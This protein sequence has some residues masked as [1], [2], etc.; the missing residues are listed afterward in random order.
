M[1]PPSSPP[2]SSTPPPQSRSARKLNLEERLRASFSIGELSNQTSPDPSTR[3]SP[4]PQ[5]QQQPERV[6]SPASTPL[7]D[8]PALSP[9]IHNPQ[10]MHLE[11]DPLHVL[12]PSPSHP[13]AEQITPPAETP[14]EHQESPQQQ[15]APPEETP[16]PPQPPSEEAPPADKEAPAEQP[17]SDLPA[18]PPSPEKSEN[19]ELEEATQ[20]SDVDALQERLKLVEQRFADVSSSFKRIQAEKVAADAILRDITPLESISDSDALRAY[21]KNLAFKAE[22][23]QDEIRRL[24]GKLQT[25]EER[26]EELRD[27]HRLESSSQSEQIDRL[28]RQVEEAEAL[29]KASQ[30]SITQGESSV[31]A[32]KAE[33]DKLKTDV[34][35]AHGLVKEEEE[36]RVKAISL[37]KSV[38]QKLVKAE[39]DREEAT[40]EV[41]VLKEKEKAEREKE[42]AERNRLQKEIESVNN[43]RE[44]AVAGL[45]AQFDKEVATLKERF[46]RDSAAMRSQYELEAINAKSAHKN[47]LAAKNQQI[48]SL[49]NSVQ[50]LSRDKNN[51]FEQAE[52]RQAEVESSQTALE[53][54]Q[55]Q[56]IELQYQLREVQ[57]RLALV[58][59]DLAEALRGAPSSVAEPTAPAPSTSAFTV[60]EAK[61]ETKIDD[62]TRAVATL[63][64]ERGESEAQWSRKLR[65]KS[66][67]VDLLRGT[68]GGTAE[69]KAR[70]EAEAA[71][72]RGVIERLQEEGR[73]LKAQIKDLQELI[74]KRD[75]LEGSSRAQE[76]EIAARISL[77]ERTVEEGKTREAQLRASN[78]TLREELRKV[79]SSAALLEKQRNPGVGYWRAENGS[80][81]SMSSDN[82]SRPSSPAPTTPK[83]DEEVNL[84]YLRN[85]ILQFLEHKEMRPNLVKVLSIILHFTPQETRR[86]VAKV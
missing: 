83:S 9:T 49:E 8:S 18:E 64:R 37:L 72:L 21:I 36:K 65:E 59:E 7:P 68:L 32:Y 22:V 71:E 14:Q 4:A 25:Q 60:L 84:E 81:T 15:Q 17:A 30:S 1:P 24:T 54:V 52:L 19:E 74:A 55:S 62:L 38:R 63:E 67:E 77:L 73:A 5:Q 29:V 56:N 57:D 10:P 3:G 46:E 45:K 16:E 34:A 58:S 44:K 51:F 26:I 69:V 43:E 40:K 85:V 76:E 82:G 20:P 11:L 48:A 2:P 33:I 31:A 23:A 42:Q 79:Q 75:E 78:K 13:L 50:T 86:L 12:S 27:T 47:E 61:Y 28:K 70:G 39:K 80:R 53:A 35:K 41:H 6:S 66:A